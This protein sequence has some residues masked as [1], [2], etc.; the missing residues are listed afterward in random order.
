MRCIKAGALFIL[1][2]HY[3]LLLIAST[4]YLKFNDV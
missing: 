1:L 2:D 4:R 3:D